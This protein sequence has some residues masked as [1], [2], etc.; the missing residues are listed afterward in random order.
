[1]LKVEH[2][3]ACL[4]VIL[5]TFNWKWGKKIFCLSLFLSHTLKKQQQNPQS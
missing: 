4:I 3:L 5:S 2:K 1:M